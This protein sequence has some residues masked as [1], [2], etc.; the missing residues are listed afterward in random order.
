M[1]PTFTALFEAHRWLAESRDVRY[2]AREL[3]EAQIAI[4]RARLLAA[5]LS[6][7][8]EEDEPAA[9]LFALMLEAD[10]LRGL[11]DAFPVFAARN[12]ARRRNQDLVLNL[13]DRI[14]LRALQA[15]ARRAPEHLREA[16]DELRAF[17]AARLRPA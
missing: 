1:L 7:G 10:A 13:T 9:L 14:E 5:G 16:F 6:A 2:A 12:L 11:R 15:R 4:A 8:R 17:V 3:E